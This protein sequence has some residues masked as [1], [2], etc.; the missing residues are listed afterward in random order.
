MKDVHLGH[1][2]IEGCLRRA[3]KSVYWPGMNNDIKELI[4]TCETLVD[5]HDPLYIDI[6]Y[7]VMVFPDASLYI[8]LGGMLVAT[9]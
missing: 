8:Y 2:G 5:K 6:H 1:T 9:F 7:M 3:R 4:Q